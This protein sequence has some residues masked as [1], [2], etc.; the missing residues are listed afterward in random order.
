M[1]CDRIQKSFP[2]PS[3]QRVV[4]ADFSVHIQ[5]GAFC[6][7]VGPSGAGK[8][9]LLRC[10]T[11][12]TPVDRGEL[13]VDGA[14]VVGVPQ[15]L[16]VVFQDYSRS[17][18][19]WKTL[20]QNVTFALRGVERR[21]ARERAREALDRVGVDHA[22]GQYPW[23]VSGGMQQRCAFARAIAT[24]AR[25]VVM[26]EPFASVD[27]LT[28]ITLEDLLLEL[29]ADL[30]FTAIFVTH[31]IEEAI[32]LGDRV[33]VLSSTPA[34]VVGDFPIELSRPRDQLVTKAHPTFTQL[35]GD[36]LGLIEGVRGGKGAGPLAAEDA[37]LQEGG[38]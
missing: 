22:A 19:P 31:D 16:S 5:A 11:G 10:L 9:T 13:R 30:R 26:D 36:V 20:E 33:L 17:L 6:V 24:H 18:Y 25:L 23:Q 21:E 12:L 27:A 37:R 29:W 2:S 8:T 4:I 7:V 15:G 28:R 38:R 3:G 1:D 14:R 35:K 32:Y 34:R